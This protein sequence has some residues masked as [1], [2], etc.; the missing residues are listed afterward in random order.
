MHQ[1]LS[2]Q[3]NFSHLLISI[4]L[5]SAFSWFI[6][7]IGPDS[8]WQYVVFYGL[9]AGTLFFFLLFLFA[10]LRFAI[11]VAGSFCVYFLLRSFNLL[12]PIYGILLLFCAISLVRLWKQTKKM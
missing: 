10:N 5:L 7:T 6:T 8:I 4:V 2:H 12:H 3:R 11:I 1:F 9:L